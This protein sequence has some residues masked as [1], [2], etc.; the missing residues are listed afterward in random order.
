MT[1]ACSGDGVKPT[2]PG[3]DRLSWVTESPTAS[4][5]ITQHMFANGG[6]P[7]GYDKIA[8]RAVERMDVR[9][10]KEARMSY[11]KHLSYVKQ[12]L[13]KIVNI[14]LLPKTERDW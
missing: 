3:E 7:Q 2:A 4:Q 5:V 1:Q 13:N 12:T 6:N 9:H 10:F 14:E 11:G 8:W